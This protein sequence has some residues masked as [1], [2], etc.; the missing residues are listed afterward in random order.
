MSLKDDIIADIRANGPMPLSDYMRRCNTHYYSTR[1]PFGKDGDFITAPDI[2]QMFGELIGLWCADLW[3]R[4][5]SPNPFRLVELGPGRGTLMQDALRATKGVPGFHDALTV[6][7]VEI[8]PVLREEQKKRVPDA[9][10]HEDVL[11]AG[12]NSS[13]IL[14]A[15]EFFDA[16][17][18]DQFRYRALVGNKWDRRFVA[19]SPE[20][21]LFFT[22]QDC[23]PIH[24]PHLSLE[25]MK[26]I[27][28]RDIMEYSELGFTLASEISMAT[29]GFPGAILAIDYGYLSATHGETLQA[30]KQNQ[31]VHPLEEPGEADLTAHV[32]FTMLTHMANED[33]RFHGPTTQGQFLRKLGLDA[34]AATLARAHPERADEFLA[35]AARL[36][37]AGQ[38]GTLFKVMAITSKDWPT[39][40]GFDA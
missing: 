6:H 40:A 8:S 38:M 21:K 35:Q 19:C 10:W 24:T 16:L 14:I 2:S 29:E 27:K 5:G 25:E 13:C 17:E 18:T 15:N 3:Q 30:L 20:D 11:F 32:N 12:I 39:P 34:R 31:F 36:A 1:I 22:W 33:S 37:D 23:N 4:A 28:P 7:F 9:V 26:Q